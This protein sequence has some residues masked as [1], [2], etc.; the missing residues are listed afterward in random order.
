MVIINI[1]YNQYFKSNKIIQQLID[2][3]LFRKNKSGINLST[4]N[5]YPMATLKTTSLNRSPS[6]LTQLELST[7]YGV[8]KGNPKSVRRTKKPKSNLNPIPVPK[9]S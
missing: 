9:A 8:R 6:L 7:V 5:G 1:N 4:Q 3:F 2:S